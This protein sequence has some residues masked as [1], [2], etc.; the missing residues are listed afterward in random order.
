MTKRVLICLLLGYVTCQLIGV[1]PYLLRGEMG[2]AVADA[3]SLPGAVMSA[4]F[5]P[6]GIHSEVGAMYWPIVAFLGN[7]LFY[8]AIWFGL[9][10]LFRRLRKP[11]QSPHA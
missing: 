8:A 7:L 9:L 2:D 5:F 1:I 6:Q 10:Y 4:P 3:L 11:Q